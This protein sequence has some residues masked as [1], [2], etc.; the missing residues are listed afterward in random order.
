MS[1]KTIFLHIGTEKTGTSY[2]QRVFHL[3]KGRLAA[4]RGVLYPQTHYGLDEEQVTPKHIFLRKA[5]TAV[6]VQSVFPLN[7]ATMIG[8]KRAFYRRNLARLNPVF[9]EIDASPCPKVFLS[10]EAVYAESAYAAPFFAAL[11][12]R[13]D[14][15]VVVQFRR[16]DQYLESLYGE[17]VKNGTA[18]DIETYLE[19]AEVRKRL[20]YA[21]MLRHWEAYFEPA[22]IHVD[23]YGSD[24]ALQKIF[25]VLGIAPLKKPKE[26]KFDNP[27]LNP[28]AIELMRH[29]NARNRISPRWPGPRQH[30]DLRHIVQTIT[31]PGKPVFLTREQRLAILERYRAGNDDIAKRYL[32]PRG[33]PKSLFET[34]PD[35][36][37]PDDAV[38]RPLPSKYKQELIDRL[39]Q[40]LA[41]IGKQY[42]L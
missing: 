23:R 21:A 38:M 4:R 35:R 36:F 27:S 42:N 37:P 20:D 11:R 16:Q 31:K 10:E 29:V 34:A 19:T 7:L 30:R 2:I 25:D 8:G 40:E 26:P 28:E 22:C 3:N 12:E 33:E 41:R 17:S 1:D 39:R 9:A 18:S 13:Y 15:H 5:V 24:D 14:V 6:H 32:A